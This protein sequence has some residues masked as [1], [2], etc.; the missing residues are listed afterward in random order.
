MAIYDVAK[1]VLVKQ[2][3][4]SDPKPDETTVVYATL[5]EKKLVPKTESKETQAKNLRELSV[6]TPVRFSTLFICNV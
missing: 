5:D 4:G 1:K 2:A 3:T 6:H